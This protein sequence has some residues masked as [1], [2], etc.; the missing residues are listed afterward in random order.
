MVVEPYFAMTTP[1]PE[2]QSRLLNYLTKQQRDRG[3]LSHITGLPVSLITEYSELS[4][5]V[6]RV[7]DYLYEHDDCTLDVNGVAKIGGAN[8]K[9]LNIDIEWLIDQ[10][11]IALVIHNYERVIF[12]TKRGEEMVY[13]G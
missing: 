9:Q 12:L 11:I 2:A 3:L 8:L 6:K 10:N 13:E 1:P 7:V 5:S 4:P